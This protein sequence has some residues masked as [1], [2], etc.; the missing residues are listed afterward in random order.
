MP[1][2]LPLLRSLASVARRAP[3]D[4][5]TAEGRSS[6]RYRRI[7][8]SAVATGFSRIVTAVVGLLA[9]PLALG[10]LGKERYGVFATIT[11][12]VAWVG[13]FDFGLL[14]GLLNRI[15]EAD[16]RDDRASAKAYF[17]SALLLLCAVSAVLLA[18]AAVAVPA[19]PWRAVLA[20][21]TVISDGD[22][23][24]SVA[25]ALACVIAAMPLS[26][27]RQVYAGYQRAYVGALFASAG[28]ALTLLGVVAV[29]RAG[30]PMPLLV[31]VLS[32]ASIVAVAANFLYMLAREMPWLRPGV[33]AIT[34]ASISRL[35]STSTPMFLFQ[36]G[37]LLVNESQALILAH[38]AGLAVVTD[39]SVLWRV[40]VTVVGVIALASGSFVPSFREAYER[41]DRVWLTRA[42]RRLVAIRT[43]LAVA[44][45][46]LLVV[47][48]NLFLRIWLRRSDVQLDLAAWGGFSG[49][50]VVAAWVSGYMDLLNVMDR[51]W[52]QVGFVLVQGAMTIGLTAALGARYGVAG[53]TFAMFVPGVLV[54][55]VIAPRLARRLLERSSPH[56]AGS[57]A[58]EGART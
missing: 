4:T 17:S 21:G 29:V 7:L 44:A 47:T 48:G 24:W 41:G 34:R 16:G 56:G 2:V 52:P 49:M 8:L 6:E 55:G 37:A 1:S 36:L 11:A 15:A 35:V 58:G 45:S 13:L 27:V 19:I 26:V 51:V 23:R 22:L 46:A 57:V 53:A 3:F 18:A 39:Y 30:A 38:R 12:L 5:A 20:A 14:N 9:V 32:G 25:A 43:V 54:S 28:A 40:Y 31:L 10:H 33:G 42:F 50:C